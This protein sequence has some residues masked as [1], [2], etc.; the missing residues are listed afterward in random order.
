MH[1]SMCSRLQGFDATSRQTKVSLYFGT[2]QY[3]MQ[4]F[5]PQNEG[6]LHAATRVQ[7]AWQRP[8]GL[9][10]VEVEGAAAKVGTGSTGAD[11]LAATDGAGG[12]SGVMCELP[13]ALGVGSAR[14]H[15]TAQALAR[16]SQAVR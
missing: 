11:G 5:I 16:T 4:S 13:V 6:T 14:V 12:D 9:E 15:C 10:D 8:I 1:V 2:A 3:S 7:R